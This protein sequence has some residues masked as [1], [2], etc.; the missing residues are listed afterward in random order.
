MEKVK[1]LS[2]FFPAYNEE[3]NI[4]TTITKALK[5]LSKV[6]KKWEIV[7][8]NDGSTD[9]TGKIIEGM[10]EKEK[11][12]RMITHTP[13]RGYGAALKTGLFQSKYGLIVFTDADGQFDFSEITKFLNEIK[14]ADLVIGYRL[15]RRDSFLRRLI[16][17]LLKVWNFVFFQVWFRDADCGF[18][19]VRKEVVDKIGE[20]KTESAITEAEFL[21]KAKKTGFKISEVGVHHYPRKA[22]KQTGGNFK[23]IFKAVRETF[24]LLKVLWKN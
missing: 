9:Q 7:V 15:E 16:G 12:I 18:K 24:L 23:V 6:A 14:K 5:I 8:V 1:E 17:F 22:G 19:L 2:V 3:A 13:N 11:K 21:I 10:I 20:L 4:K